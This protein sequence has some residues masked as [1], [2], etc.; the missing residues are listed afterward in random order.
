MPDN[1]MLSDEGSG[2]TVLGA[3]ATNRPVI[4][5]LPPVQVLEQDGEK[6]LK[7]PLLLAGRWKSRYGILEFSKKIFDKM[8]GNHQSD[9]VG[10]ELSYDNRH[11]PEF[12]AIAWFKSFAMEQIEKAGKKVWMFFGL[13]KPTP[14]GLEEI[15]SGAYKYA[16]IE[17]HP[18]Y[19]HPL[20]ALSEVLT[21]EDLLVEEADM[22]EV[23]EKKNTDGDSGI[24]ALE[25]QVAE[26]LAEREKYTSLSE[27]VADLQAQNAQY[28]RIALSARI[29]ASVVAAE[30]YRDNGKA[31]SKLFLDWFKL[32]LSGDTIGEGDEAITL[33]SDDAGDV[34]K[35]V[36]YYRRAMIWLSENL[37]GVVPVEPAN[38]KRDTGKKILS[39]D[40]E[41]DEDDMGEIASVWGGTPKA[42]E[43]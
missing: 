20:V 33:S 1:I 32:C 40:G 42:K 26:L 36:S 15:E 37:P 4:K 19:K 8:V 39:G 16:S 3:G 41:Y 29:D 18:N 28:A 34:D 6:L 23:D 9:V 24:Q 22:P 14:K 27:Q 5:G 30:A 7:I 35:V 38:T 12:G 21:D 25:Q 2:P 10:N 13:A 43:D 11:K 31:H 17:F